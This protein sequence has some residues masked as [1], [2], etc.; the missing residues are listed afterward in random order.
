MAVKYSDVLNDY[1]SDFKKFFTN[2]YAWLII[3][4]F[5]AMPVIFSLSARNVDI[6]L[7]AVYF[8]PVCFA[9]VSMMAHGVSLPP[10]MYLMPLSVSDRKKYI[11][12]MVVCKIAVPLLFTVVFDTLAAGFI[13]FTLQTAAIQF[14]AVL[15]PSATCALNSEC[16]EPN[17]KNTSAMLYTEP[18]IMSGMYFA[19][20]HSDNTAYTVIFFTILMIWNGIAGTIVLIRWPKKREFCAR[21]ENTEIRGEEE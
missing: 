11:D 2:K 9:V 13:R 15:C 3:L 12:R 6:P 16:Y 17:S 8:I 4:A 19:E 5:A 21:F 10:V 20:K 18:L 14:A 1:Y 7:S